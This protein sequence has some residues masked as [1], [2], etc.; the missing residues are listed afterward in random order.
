MAEGGWTTDEHQRYFA[1]STPTPP[2]TSW[3]IDV[4]RSQ[5]MDIVN[6][7]LPRMAG[8]KGA[9]MV[10]GHQIGAILDYLENQR[11]AS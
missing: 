8:S 3:W 2:E 11:R 5:W 10:D 9:R 7:Q 1:P 6:A 4:P